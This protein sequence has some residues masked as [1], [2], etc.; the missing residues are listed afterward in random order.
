[1]VDDLD[2]RRRTRLRGHPP[3]G[4]RGSRTSIAPPAIRT[5]K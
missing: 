5:G 1:V 2:R 3:V 4:V